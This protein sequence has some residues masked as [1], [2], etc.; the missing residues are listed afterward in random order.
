MELGIVIKKKKEKVNKISDRDRN[1]LSGYISLVLKIG[2]EIEK[3]SL[4]IYDL[5]S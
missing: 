2:S 5:R 4:Q 1:I 3:P